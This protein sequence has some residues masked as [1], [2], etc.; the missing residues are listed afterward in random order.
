MDAVGLERPDLVLG[1]R[2]HDRV[3]LHA[4]DRA[5]RDHDLTLA[6]QVA[7]LEHEVSDVVVVVDDEAVDVAEVMPVRRRDRARAADL[8]LALRDAVVRPRSRGRRTSI[9]SAPMA[10][11]PW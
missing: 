3:G 5:D 9:G 8:D 7:V 10:S 6:P 11:R 2:E 1:E 4:R